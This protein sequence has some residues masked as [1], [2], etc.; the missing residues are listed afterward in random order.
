MTRTTWAA[1]AACGWALIFALP[2]F[3]WAVG[4]TVGMSTIARDPDAISLLN[5]PFV[6]FGT[7]LLKV[8]SGMLALALVQPWERRFGHWLRRATWAAGGFLVVYGAA[9]QIQH[10]LM[11]AR[12]V[13]TP[14][15]LGT[16]AARWH[17]WL[18]DPWWLLGGVLFLLAAWSARRGS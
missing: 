8:L 2:S 1:Y 17:F 10:G 18:W 6:V 14:D 5:E 16:T 12:L 11:L 4:G 3:Y 7:G 9:L 13:D 15:A